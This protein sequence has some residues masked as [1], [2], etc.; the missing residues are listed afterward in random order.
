MDEPVA[1][2]Q[3]LAA[4][5]QFFLHQEGDD[6]TMNVAGLVL[7]DG[8]RHESFAKDLRDLFAARIHRMPRLRQRLA[9]VPLAGAPPVWVD[10]TMF[11]LHS[12]IRVLE[13]AAPPDRDELVALAGRLAA[14]PLERDRPLWDVSVVPEV[15]DGTSAAVIR[16]HHALVDG[17]SG[18]ELGKLLYATDHAAAIEPPE[19]WVP[20]PTPSAADL[21]AEALAVRAGH[22]LRSATEQALAGADPAQQLAAYEEL[23]E[24]LIS[25]TRLGPTPANPFPPAAP[26]SRRYAITELGDNQIRMVA[27]RFGVTLEVVVLAIVAGAVHQLLRA[28]GESFD[29]LRV[30]LPVTRR[31]RL[32]TAQLGNHGTFNIIDLPVGPMS[33]DQR[34]GEVEAAVTSARQ[35]SQAAAASAMIDMADRMPEAVNRAS[36]RWLNDRSFVHAV[37]SYMRGPRRPMYLA[38]RSHLGT[39][40]ILPRSN[41]IGLLIGVMHLGGVAAVGL[42]ADPRSVPDLAYLSSALGRSADA[43]S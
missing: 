34:V 33:D 25:F 40:P 1:V 39:Y 7:V 38:G 37:V 8:H 30:L 19:P 24:G 31:N 6:T 32:R 41:G 29:A 4:H 14:V 17:M 23:L 5:D 22:H 9:E 21:V 13:L 20:E 28:R 36:A 26:G 18:L 42:V 12:R 27:Q 16:W 43:L 2:H 15:A 3:P 35:G 10:D 11:D